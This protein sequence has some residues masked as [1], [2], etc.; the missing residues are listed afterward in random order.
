MSN[1]YDEIVRN[2]IYSIVEEKGISLDTE[3]ICSSVCGKEL[4]LKDKDFALVRGPEILLTCKVL[5]CIGQAFT[6]APKNYRGRL[7]D[8]LKL[9]LDNIFNRGIFY[10]TITGLLKCL[11]MVSRSIH[12]RDIEPMKCGIDLSN[13]LFYSKGYSPVLH[14]GYQPTH[15]EWLFYRL[16]NNILVTDLRSD[17]IWR[18]KKELTIYD[19]LNNS[20]YTALVNTILVTASSIVN[21][22]FWD[23][24]SKAIMLKKD[25]IVYGVSGI[26]FLYIISKYLSYSYTNIEYY[27][28]YSK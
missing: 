1:Y 14:I 21:N 24:F 7:G 10:A 22:T 5:D 3:V 12:C 17:N 27:C 16:K 26:G 6:V 23:I 28:P 9:N 19:G 15:V 4:G 13:K 25:I 2:I 8:I 18:K 20:V 11:G